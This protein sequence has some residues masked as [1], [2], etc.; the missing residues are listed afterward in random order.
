MHN[1][2][3]YTVKD[4]N[5]HQLAIKV[6]T[7]YLKLWQELIASDFLPDWIKPSLI[8]DTFSEVKEQL[9]DAKNQ[10]QNKLKKAQEKKVKSNEYLKKLYSHDLPPPPCEWQNPVEHIT[11]NVFKHEIEQSV[12]K[13]IKGKKSTLPTTFLSTLFH[14]SLITLKKLTNQSLPP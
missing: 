3:N 6:C 2:G 5:G 14:Q 9:D 1:K 12:E 11:P 10:K 7:S 13:N 8:P 4:K